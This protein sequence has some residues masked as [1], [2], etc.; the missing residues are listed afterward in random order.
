MKVRWRALVCSEAPA[1]Y[2]ASAASYRLSKDVFVV[3]I[4]ESELE[5]REVQ[6]Q[7]F[8]AHVVISADNSALQERPEILD[9]VRM[10][11]AAY[12]LFRTMIDCFVTANVVGHSLAITRARISRDETNFFR[13]GLIDKAVEGINRS[14]FNNLADDIALATNR[15]DHGGFA[16]MGWTAAVV[17]LAIFPMAIFLFCRR[18]RFR[19]S[20]QFPSIA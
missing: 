17:L 13:D 14:I 5:L 7:I 16:G 12:I 1:S 9:V 2:C 4:V 15:T 19:Q 6:R 11:F 20:R 8:F 10:Y 3:P 18:C